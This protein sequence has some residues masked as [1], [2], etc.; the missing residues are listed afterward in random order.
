MIIPYRL[1]KR[2]NPA[3]VVGNIMNHKVLLTSILVMIL[4]IPVA[5]IAI[6]QANSKAEVTAR[7]K[8]VQAVVYDR[9]RG[10]YGKDYSYDFDANKF[11]T[12][13]SPS[14][15]N[16]LRNTIVL[17]GKLNEN[18]WKEIEPITVDLQ[19]TKSWGAAINS[20]SVRAANNGSWLFMSFQWRDI[21]E[22]RDEAARIKR[23]DGSFFYNQTHFFSDN[24]YVGWWMNEGQP[25]VKPWFNAH[26]AGTTLGKV[27]W[28]NEDPKALASL[29]IWK[30]YYT[31]DE[32]PRWPNVY[33]PVLD[34]FPF[35]RH[36]GE[37]QTI[38]YPHMI[39]MYTNITASYA[40]TYLSHVSGCAF[41]DKDFFG[42]EVMANGHWDNG[43]WTVEIARPFKPHPL[44]EALKAT[45]K[46]EGGNS[47]NMFFGAGDG[48]RGENEDVGAIS[49][50]LTV[51]M[52]SSPASISP[53]LIV[54]GV[55]PVVVLGGWLLFRHSRA[56]R[57]TKVEGTNP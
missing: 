34:V 35:G 31:D 3:K 54:L 42:Y 13:S 27:P 24:L 9:V 40:I 39:Q 7:Y 11:K 50:W 33:F 57:R 55:A 53:I 30:A 8:D 45:P 17:D 26:F 5:P 56:A 47:Y 41:P 44:N 18:V 28:K 32:A 12:Y 20:V 4:L 38:P 49:Q 19:P 22:S 36:K 14:S 52:E 15:I 16:D 2:F 37:P 51:S 10:V 25:T 46:F 48:Q 6:A 43:L 1:G 29:W 21:T 23:P